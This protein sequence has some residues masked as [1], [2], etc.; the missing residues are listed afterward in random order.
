MQRSIN[1]LLSHYVIDPPTIALL[2][3]LAPHMEGGADGLEE[4]FYDT[5]LSQPETARFLN[6]TA[7]LARLKQHHRTW[8]L[9][10]FTGPFDNS[11]LRHLQ[12]I[13]QT[14]VRIGLPGRAVNAAMNLVRTFCIEQ[15][16]H[17]SQSEEERMQAIVAVNR[18][19]DLH[20]DVMTAS[21]R[22]TELRGQL[23]N[24]RIMGGLIFL[25]TRVLLAL[26]VG[27]VVALMMVALGVGAL[28]AFDLLSV[29]TGDPHLGLVSALGS[30]LIMWTVLE[31][32]DKE[33]R[34]LKGGEFPITA[35]LAVAMAAMVREILIA[36]LSHDSSNKDWVMVGGLLALGMVYYLVN[37]ANAPRLVSEERRHG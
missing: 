23:V 17:W 36:A 15:I 10:L 30:L 26:Q 37:R 24:G 18:M 16:C 1:Y 34:H 9:S 35:F 33:V 28:F 8:F 29:F 12:R 5:L 19:L 6:N 22:E 14:H 4:R 7:I 20:L 25:G 32:M 3:R 13:G 31:L 2:A 21:Y 11:Y 27:M